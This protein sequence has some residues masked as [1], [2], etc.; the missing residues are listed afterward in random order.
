MLR[1]FIPTWLKIIV[2]TKVHLTDYLAAD[3]KKTNIGLMFL[4]IPSTDGTN[5]SAVVNAM[6]RIEV[7]GIGTQ[8]AAGAMPKTPLSLH[9]E[10]ELVAAIRALGVKMHGRMV[11]RATMS[12]GV[13]IILS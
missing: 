9:E 2:V 11:N 7:M 13:L 5:T 4:T 12:I 8:I 10:L 6:A 1:I 3:D